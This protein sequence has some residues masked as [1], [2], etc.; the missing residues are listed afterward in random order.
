MQNILYKISCIRCM[1]SDILYEISNVSKIFL[2][3]TLD[4]LYVIQDILYVILVI[5]IDIYDI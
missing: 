2:Y 3:G 5:L 1:I 4:I